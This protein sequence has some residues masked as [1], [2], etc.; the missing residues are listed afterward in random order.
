[1]LKKIS[2]LLFVLSL[3][4]L[5]LSCELN[6]EV[7][8]SGNNVENLKQA[9]VESKKESPSKKTQSIKS[10][11]I[12]SIQGGY[13]KLNNFFSTPGHNPS[14]D[15]SPFEEKYLSSTRSG[16]I[17]DLYPIDDNS[18]RQKWNI[19]RNYEP[20]GDY[21]YYHIIISG[22]V[23]GRRKYLSSTSN[24]GKIDLYHYDDGSGRQRWIITDGLDGAYFIRVLKGIIPE[25][26]RFLVRHRV[27]QQH[28]QHVDLRANRRGVYDTWLIVS[29]SN[30]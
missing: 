25:N 23:G 11:S 7:L 6:N 2:K 27:G 4:V 24:G 28:T 9:A 20:N 29:S 18:G 15:F 17:V 3:F 1:M 21:Y 10:S 13:I 26:K 5:S 12:L 19:V 30:N 8:E 22:G 16:D 14:P